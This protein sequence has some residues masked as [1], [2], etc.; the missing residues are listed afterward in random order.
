[1]DSSSLSE[2]IRENLIYMFKTV[3]IKSTSSID[4]ILRAVY[5]ETLLVYFK[6]VQILAEVL[7]ENGLRFNSLEWL[8]IILS[9]EQST[10]PTLPGLQDEPPVACCGTRMDFRN[11]WDAVFPDLYAGRRILSK[12]YSRPVA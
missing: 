8:Y 11:L 10:T 3:C 6:R 12:R 2:L 9:V 1:M 7:Y 4:F 5:I